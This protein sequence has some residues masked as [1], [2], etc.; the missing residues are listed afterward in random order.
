MKYMKV[1]RYVIISFF[2]T[3]VSF[4]YKV[5]AE[6][7]DID[8]VLFIG[9]SNMVGNG[10]M[11][12]IDGNKIDFGSLD[13]KIFEYKYNTDSLVE[14][15]ND[16]NL[17]DRLG[18]FNAVYSDSTNYYAQSE[19]GSYTFMSKF[20]KQYVKSTGRNIVMVPVAVGGRGIFYFTPQ[21]IEKE[22]MESVNDNMIHFIVKKY[23]AAVEKVKSSGNYNVKNT[24]YII[25]N[26]ESDS[27]QF[28]SSYNSYKKF[29]SQNSLDYEALNDGEAEYGREFL[30]MHNFLLNN[31]NLKF[32]AIVKPGL[33]YDDNTY[34][35]NPLYLVDSFQEKIVNTTPTLMFA[36]SKALELSQ[37]DVVRENFVDDV[38]LNMQALTKVAEDAVKNIIESKDLKVHYTIKYDCNGGR[39]KVISSNH[40]YGISKEL[41]K[42]TCNMK[43]YIFKG[44]NLDKNNKFIKYIDRQ[45]IKNLTN[46]EE[47]IT[48]YAIWEPIKHTIKYNC[49]GG[50]GEMK[51]SF[52]TYVNDFYLREN[53]CKYD[54]K[55]FLGWSQIS[56]SNI[57]KYID[58]EKVDKIDNDMTL[59]AVWEDILEKYKKEK[60]NFYY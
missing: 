5:L 17:P 29:I 19:E 41:S 48:L 55:R 11:D 42:N 23:N 13:G 12:E 53:T 31:T 45:K 58:M 52:Y 44:W 28:S 50:R 6:K 10:S 33:D 1:L 18:E 43:N 38:H 8:I 56:T 36:T 9:Q 59:Y 57:V 16:N 30:S 4:N 2:L 27:I 20:A 21:Y 26:G 22:K 7:Q 24:F 14:Y 37:K 39:G 34:S 3:F 15:S 47:D 40:V 49:N 51:D 25:Y 35:D 60:L 54:G 46:K 32:G